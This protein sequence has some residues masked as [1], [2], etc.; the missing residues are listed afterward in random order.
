MADL[1]DLEEDPALEA[2]AALSEAAVSGID[3]LTEVNEKLGA[4][5]RR[6]CRGWSW[7]RIVSSTEMVDALSCVARLAAELGRASG[8]FRRLLARMLRHEGLQ[9]TAIGRL[10]GVSRQRVSALV[11]TES[12]DLVDPTRTGKWAFPDRFEKDRGRFLA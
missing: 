1:Q 8:E 9:V 5:R 6:R 12:G 2:L 4:V 11:R 10:L 7:R 3:G